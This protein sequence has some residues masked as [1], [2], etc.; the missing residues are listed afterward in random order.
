MEVSRKHLLSISILFGLFLALTLS[1]CEPKVSN[2]LKE[3]FENTTDNDSILQEKRAFGNITL[4]KFTGLLAR[5]GIYDTTTH[6]ARNGDSILFTI[7]NVQQMNMFLGYGDGSNEGEKWTKKYKN[8]PINIHADN[9]IAAK[10]NQ[11]N[12]KEYVYIPYEMLF[13]VVDYVGQKSAPSGGGKVSPQPSSR[14]DSVTFKCREDIVRKSAGGKKIEVEGLVLKNVTDIL[15]KKYSG[16]PD[17]VRQLQ[18]IH[19]Y[20]ID[21]WIYIYDP[22]VSADVWRSASETIENYYFSSEHKYSGDCDDFAILMASFARQIGLH[23]RFVAEWTNGV[24][25]HAH[26]EYSRDGRTWYSLDWDNSAFKNVNSRH[27]PYRN[28]EI[29]NDL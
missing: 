19:K 8:L 9:T 12:G 2:Q 24:G 29:F 1:G 4:Q 16:A 22:D 17:P 18:T 10:V 21:N 6:I 14:Q 23:S 25:G 11:V 3:K 13:C 5:S 20:V 27:S 28:S 15:S 26:A 7:A